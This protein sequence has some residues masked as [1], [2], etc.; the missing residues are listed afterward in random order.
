MDETNYRATLDAL[1]RL[2]EAIEGRRQARSLI[3]AG[4]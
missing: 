3:E 4:M 1:K 2:A